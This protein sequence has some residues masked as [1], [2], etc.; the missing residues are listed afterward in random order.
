LSTITN[1]AFHEETGITWFETGS[2]LGLFNGVVQIQQEP[3]ALSDTID[4][5]LTHF[6]QRNLAFHWNLGPTSRP[7]NIGNILEA[8]GI[9]FDED[10]PGMAL[11]LPA[12][13]ENL[14]LA[15]NLVIHSVTTYELLDQWTRVWSCGAPE[16]I[17]RQMLAVY[18]RLPLSLQSPYRWYLGTVDGEPIAT[19]SLFFGGGVACIGEVVTLPQFRRQGIGAAMTLAA[20]REAR[21]AG[22]RI[23]VL[24]ASPYGINIYRRLG[25]KEFCT[26]STYRWG[27]SE[28]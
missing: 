24:T 7:S 23:A 25:F 13:N 4:R 18:S 9:H 10:E 26:V 17:G 14:Q 16:W 12:L 5:I 1:A 8:H 2:P 3:E 6:K 20:A 11:D 27:P 28:S 22:Y 15:S 19:F 21:K